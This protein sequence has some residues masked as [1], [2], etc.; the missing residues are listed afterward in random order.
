MTMFGDQVLQYGG[1]P[2]AS[3]SE[4][5]MFDDHWFV[6]NSVTASGGGKSEMLE[7]MHREG[8]GRRRRRQEWE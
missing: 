6:D 2:V 7:Q 4:A 8:D 1:V 3:A 5:S